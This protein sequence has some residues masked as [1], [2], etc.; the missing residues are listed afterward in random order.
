M[1]Q[2]A[3]EQSLLLSTEGFS[4]VNHSAV[5]DDDLLLLAEIC[6]IRGRSSQAPK[7]PRAKA[8]YLNECKRDLKER[9]GLSKTDFAQLLTTYR[10]VNGAI[11]A[12]SMLERAAMRLAS[13]ARKSELVS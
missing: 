7:D 3:V 1:T 11:T 10:T 13:K 8:N 6:G 12:R 9:Y 4:P 2:A 5:S